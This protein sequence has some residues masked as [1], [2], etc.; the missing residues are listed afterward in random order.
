MTSI[1]EEHDM[2]KATGDISLQWCGATTPNCL[3]LLVSFLI[4]TNILFISKRGKQ[5]ALLTVSHTARPQQ[6]HQKTSVLAYEVN[7]Q[8]T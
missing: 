5:G 7:M 2:N 4:I 8:K 6:V 1:M 3:I